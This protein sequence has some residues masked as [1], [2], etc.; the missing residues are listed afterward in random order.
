MKEFFIVFSY[1][2]FGALAVTCTVITYQIVR[3]G[4]GKTTSA[5]EEEN[6]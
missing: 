1:V 3:Y 5:L 4:V 6:E 2:S